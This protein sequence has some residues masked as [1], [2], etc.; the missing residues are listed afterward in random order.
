MNYFIVF[1]FETDGTNP[2]TCS[3]IQLAAIAIDPYSLEVIESSKFCSD[4]KPERKIAQETING[5]KSKTVTIDDEEYMTDDIMET[6]KWHAKVRGCTVDEVISR[7]KSSPP[8]EIVW[9]NFSSYVNKYN[10]KKS[11][12]NAPY[13]AGM[14]IRNFDMIIADRLNNEYKT[15]KMFN[16]E[17]T[18]IRDWAFHALIWE[19]DLKSRSMDN[20]RKYLGMSGENAH[21]AM[22]DVIDSA[23]IISRYLK[24][25]RNTFHKNKYKGCMK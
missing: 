7:C 10:P 6:M 12:W 13:A 25:Y 1:D 16:H 4:I 18:D 14:N 19:Q 24:F 21:D 9:K 22:Q 5:F 20:L 3:P 17:Y 15:G 23:K 8:T 11:Q 2:N